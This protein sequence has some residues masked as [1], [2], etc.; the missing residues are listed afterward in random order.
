MKSF[1]IKP[2]FDMRDE[3]WPFET[4]VD[5]PQGATLT[6]EQ[7]VNFVYWHIHFNPSFNQTVKRRVVLAVAGELVPKDYEHIGT[8]LP[9]IEPEVSEE[10]PSESATD[11]AELPTEEDFYSNYR[12]INVYIAPEFT[13]KAPLKSWSFGKDTK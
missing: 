13:T 4:V 7:F 6:A 10:E 3:K 2:F 1:T 8:L 11:L 12:L 5:L 9:Y